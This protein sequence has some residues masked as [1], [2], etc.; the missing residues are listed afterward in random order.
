MGIDNTCDL[1]MLKAYLKKNNVSATTM[2]TFYGKEWFIWKGL[3][4]C[5]FCFVDLRDL[6]VG[7]PYKRE[8][9]IYSLEYDRTIDFICPDC[10]KSF[11]RNYEHTQ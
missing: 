11:G 6:E 1:S 9:A 8:I 5:P 3:L 4:K 2:E 10:G 7:P